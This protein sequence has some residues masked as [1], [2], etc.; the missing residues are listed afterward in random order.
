MSVLS[1]RLNEKRAH[2]GRAWCDAFV[3]AFVDKDFAGAAR[4]LAPDFH[5]FGKPW[6]P[7]LWAERARAVHGAARMSSAFLGAV[8]EHM[9]RHIPPALVAELFGGLLDGEQQVY[10]YDLTRDGTRVSIGVVVCR[11]ADACTIDR[12]IDLIALKH[13]FA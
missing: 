7:A 11:N 9:L 2:H 10:L 8:E 3:A 1:H 6:E 12:V 13:A 5:W 4:R